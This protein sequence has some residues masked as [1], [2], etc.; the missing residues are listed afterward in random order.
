MESRAGPSSL[1]R[2]SSFDRF[3]DQVTDPPVDCSIID[4]MLLAD[5]GVFHSRRCAIA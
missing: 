4:D 3:A 1:D 5:V 2:R